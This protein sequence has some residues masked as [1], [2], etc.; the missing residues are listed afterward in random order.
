[1]TP[2]NTD[3]EG[4]GKENLGMNVGREEGQDEEDE[5]TSQMDVQ[6]PTSVA[7]LPVSAPTITPSTIATITTTQQATIPPTT[8]LSTLL[9]DLP[10]F[11]SLFRFDHRLKTLEA[12]FSDQVSDKV[13]TGL[14]YKAAS[15]T[16][17]SF[18]KSSEMLKNQE[19]IKSRSDKAYHAVPP[20]YTWNYIPPKPDL[21][22]ID[23]Q[24]KSESMD[25]I[26]IVSSSAV[27][28]VESKVEV[29]DLEKIKT[30]QAKDIA[31]LK[32][33]VKKL[34]RKRRS[35]TPGMNLFKIGTSRKR[36]LSDEDASK[37]GRNL[38]Q[39]SPWSIKGDHRFCVID[40][41]DT[42]DKREKYK[43]LKIP[44]SLYHS[45]KVLIL[46]PLDLSKDTKPYTW[47]RKFKIYS[48]GIHTSVRKDLQLADGED[49]AVHKELGDSLVRVTTTTSSLKAEQ[50]NESFDNK[51][52]LGEDAS[53]QGR[54][55]AINADEEITPV[56][57]QNMDEEMFV[58]NEEDD[59]VNVIEAVEVINTAKLI[60]DA[61]QISVAGDIVSTASAATTVSAT[62]I[63]IDDITLAQV[64]EEMKSTKPKN[65][66]VVI[67]EP[68]E[69]TTTIS[70]K[71]S[72]DK[73]NI[74]LIKTW[75]DI[76]AKIDVD[77]QLAERM[78][79]QEQKELS[80][81]EKATLF[82]PLC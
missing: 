52:H 21:M 72:H 60:I 61:A 66:R 76:H 30:A 63:T 77:H 73:A 26:S 25:V 74:A 67:Q 38:K 9:Q 23:E 13:K 50:E 18:V 48:S 16:E 33:R 6:T 71:Q 62:T 44:C 12:N 15:P 39:R 20:P 28:T 3:E 19:N 79:A 75:D 69:S 57:V 24:V 65:K 4:N 2:E 8:A 68:S 32:K 46:V 70:S 58:A 80:I 29:L 17:E 56:S 40:T 1:K 55:N 47:L 11:N 53:K 54:I 78:Q 5:T 64:L 43:S 14:E 34:E 81:E 27:K 35:R 82:Q 49:E 37:Q 10:N 22:F 7:P 45:L 59:K 41:L 42:R 36:S 31:D 51:E